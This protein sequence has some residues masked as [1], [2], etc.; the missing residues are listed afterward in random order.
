MI[1]RTYKDSLFV[2]L[3]GDPAN[4]SN[5]L[6]L[7]NFLNGTNYPADTPVDINTLEDVIYMGIKNDVSCIIDGNLLLAEHQ[8]TIN[9]N[10]PLRGF[11]YFGRLYEKFL[12]SRKK[13]IYSKNRL[14]LPTPEYYIIYNGKET[15]SA[16]SKLRLSDSFQNPSVRSDYEWTATMIN[17]RNPENQE[18]LKSCNILWEY[19]QFIETVNSYLRYHPLEEAVPSAV[20]ECIR[21]NIL[22]DFLTQHKA[23][24]IGMILTEYDEEEVMEMLKEEYRQEGLALGRAEGKALG[25]ALGKAQIIIDFIHS[26]KL[27]LD[28]ISQ[29]TGLSLSELAQLESEFSVN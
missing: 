8:S 14:I 23:E 28:E 18:L 19:N 29:V 4:K 22:K 25:K 7:F 10:M 13:M 24:V 12:A 20:N 5:L 26:G 21:G 11:L 27:P 17:I 15:A 9:P 3:F 1:K 16:I 2:K 6:S